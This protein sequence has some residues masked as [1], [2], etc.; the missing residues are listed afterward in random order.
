MYRQ[1]LILAGIV[2]GMV[3]FGGSALAAMPSAPTSASVGWPHDDPDFDN[4][5]IICGDDNIFTKEAVDKSTR[6]V[7]VLQTGDILSQILG[8]KSKDSKCVIS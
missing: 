1:G 4:R 7:L 3:M 2:G 6:G 5:V 8:I